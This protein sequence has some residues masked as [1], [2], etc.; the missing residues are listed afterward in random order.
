MSP[1]ASPPWSL[2]G[3]ARAARRASLA[4]RAPRARWEAEHA[5]RV[6]VVRVVDG[7]AVDGDRESAQQ[8]GKL[9]QRITPRWFVLRDVHAG[10]AVLMQPRYAM[11]R[12]SAGAS[13]LIA[14]QGADDAQ[15][16][17]GGAGGGG[18]RSHG[19]SL[20]AAIGRL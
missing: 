16:A 1:P 2:S 17:G 10:D 9:V 8:L 12:S 5:A 7:L 14:A 4:P 15:R 11:A 18:G 3:T 20:A 19:F 13:T 6:A